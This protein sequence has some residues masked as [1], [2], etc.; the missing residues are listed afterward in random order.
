MPVVHDDR[1]PLLRVFAVLFGVLAISNL[2]KPLRLGGAQTGFVFF[3]ERLSGTPNAVA[4]P[5]FGLFLAVYAVGLWRL[6]RYALP[7]AWLYAAYV[8]ANLVLF[9]IRTPQPPAPGRFV[10]GLAY[11]AI[12][13]GVSGGAAILLTR[14][15]GALR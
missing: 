9:P 12:A 4:G 6:R 1:R 5:L 14:R 8:L 7:M 15:R 11:A 10:F 2:L 3:G 13:L